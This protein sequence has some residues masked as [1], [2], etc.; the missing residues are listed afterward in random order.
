[1]RPPVTVAIVDDDAIVRSALVS[2]VSATPGFHVVH[3]CTDGAQAVEVIVNA[4]VDVVI[5][6]VRMPKLDGIRATEALRR[7]L[8]DIKILVITSFDEDDAVREALQAGANGFLLKDTSPRGLI[9]AIRAVMEGSSVVSPGPITSLLLNQKRPKPEPPADLGL[10]P[11]ELHVLQLLCAAYSNTEIASELHVTE[12]T[13]KT[14]VSAIMMKLNV[15]SRLKAVVRA[16]ELGLVNR[17]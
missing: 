6:D 4:P 5:T 1:M 11:R 14:H 8:P 9:D 13:V 7:A 3:E 15:T 10:S 17:A 16:Y 2:Y 12:S